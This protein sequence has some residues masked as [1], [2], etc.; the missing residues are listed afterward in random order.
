MAKQFPKITNKLR[1]RKKNESWQFKFF[2][3]WFYCFFCVCFICCSLIYDAVFFFNFY[4]VMG[5]NFYG[6]YI[7]VLIHFKIFVIYLWMF[8]LRE[9]PCQNVWCT[10][11]STRLPLQFRKRGRERWN[12]KVTTM[13]NNWSKTTNYFSNRHN[14]K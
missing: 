5:I 10:A 6:V 7:A 4:W 13:V 9:I 14:N 3:W 2:Y 8:V 11:C 1:Q 12:S